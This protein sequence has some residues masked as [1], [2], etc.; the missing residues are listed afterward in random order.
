MI[1]F[2]LKLIVN[3]QPRSGSLA[4]VPLAT[5]NALNTTSDH[6]EIENKANSRWDYKAALEHSCFKSYH[7]LTIDKFSA[8]ARPAAI[9]VLQNNFSR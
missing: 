2:I 3:K 7:E 9:A 1:A 6:W 4:F 5:V 8:G